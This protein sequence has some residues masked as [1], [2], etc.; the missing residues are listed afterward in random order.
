V[1]NI[2]PNLKAGNHFQLFSAAV[3]GLASVS[4][5]LTNSLGNPYQWRND[6]AVNGS[7]TLTNVFVAAPTTNANITKVSLSG[8]N[9]LVHGTNNNV[10]N[11]SFHYEVLRTTNIAQPLTNWTVVVTN[12]FNPDGTFDYT[13]PIVP[14][15]PRQFIDVKAV[16]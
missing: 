4:L 13:N 6:L 5:P 14:G 11:T 9:L 12:S 8:T 3:P 10:P 7:I 16:P 15:T 2:G 1:T